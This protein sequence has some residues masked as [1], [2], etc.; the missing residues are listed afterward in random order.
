MQY[1][2]LYTVEITDING[3]T[4]YM[5]NSNYVTEEGKNIYDWEGKSMSIAIPKTTVFPNPMILSDPFESNNASIDT[6]NFEAYKSVSEVEDKE[7]VDGRQRRYKTDAEFEGLLSVI[8]FILYSGGT[9]YSAVNMPFTLQETEK[10]YVYY[11]LLMR[12]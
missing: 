9:P 3:D 5:R 4:R 1:I 11:S 12:W 2:G 7:T 10:M 8:G 6:G